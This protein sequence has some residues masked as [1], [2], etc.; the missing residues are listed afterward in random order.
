MSYY[1]T[2]LSPTDA[3]LFNIA[4]GTSKSGG[5]G[6]ARFR[7]PDTAQYMNQFIIHS[8][9]DIVE[10][11]QWMNGNMYVANYNSMLCANTREPQ[12]SQ[13]H[14]HLPP[15]LCLHL[16]LPHPLRRALPPPPPTPPTPLLDRWPVR[17]TWRWWWQQRVTPGIVVFS[18][19][20]GGRRILAGVE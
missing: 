1:F 3:P 16:R 20:A 2:I 14:R 11:S 19:S 15:G 18:L 17:D 12:V 4:F 7:F 6:I 5:D 10:E 13:T 8:S 9:L